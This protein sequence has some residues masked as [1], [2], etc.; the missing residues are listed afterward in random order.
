MIMNIDNL[1]PGD[2][3][4]EI[5]TDYYSYFIKSID[6][7]VKERLGYFEPVIYKEITCTIYGLGGRIVEE[8]TRIM[9]TKYYGSNKFVNNSYI[10]YNKGLNK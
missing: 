6:D 1:K 3:L 9:F 4:R 5:G 10:F 2:I 7:K 8:S